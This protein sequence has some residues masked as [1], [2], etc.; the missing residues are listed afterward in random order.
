MS[1]TGKLLSAGWCGKPV[2]VTGNPGVRPWV[3]YGMRTEE[4][5]TKAPLEMNEVDV[6]TRRG[7]DRRMWRYAYLVSLA[8]HILV[9]MPTGGRPIP[10]LPFPA[11]GP[12]ANDDRAAAGGLQAINVV[13]PPPRPIVRPR[14]PLAVEIDIDPVVIEEAPAFDS[15][16]LV[17]EHPGLDD[18]GLANGNGLGD[19]GTVTEGL[20]RL[21]PPS[22]RGMII[23]PANRGLRGAEIDVW[24]LVDASGKVVADSTRL[25]PPTRDR[26]FNRQLIRE[27]AQWVFR[28]G[29]KD[30]E[31]VVAWFVYKI[32][33]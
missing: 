16:A 5:R 28:P 32:S 12:K 4:N 18:P 1:G 8:F 22:P 27:A 7:R 26:G 19:G 13:S 15:A 17:G 14:V 24:V 29:T 21:M 23:P 33:M 2:G 3:V 10:T 30:G 31:P 9:L 25:D 20:G 11:V 6:G